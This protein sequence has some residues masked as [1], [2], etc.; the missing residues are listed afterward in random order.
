MAADKEKSDNEQVL[1]EVNR[2]IQDG[3]TDPKELIERL[4]QSISNYI[5]DAEQGDDITMLAIKFYG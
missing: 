1:N 2:A 3:Q 5:G 4:K